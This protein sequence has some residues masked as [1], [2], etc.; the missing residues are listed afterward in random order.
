[1]TD[2][3]LKRRFEA[4]MQEIYDRA[5]KEVGYWATRYLQM[6]RRRGGMD[7]ARYLLH[8]RVTSDGYARLRDAGRLDLTVEALVLRPE[9]A[10]LFD[11][12]ELEQASLRLKQYKSMPRPEE[13]E[14]SAELLAVLE[15]AASASPADRISYR[16]QIAEH[17]SAAIIAMLGWVDQ[18]HSPGLAIAVIEA[19]GRHGE[20]QRALGALRAL[21]G[22]LRDWKSVIDPAVQ[23]LGASPHGPAVVPSARPRRR[24]EP[25]PPRTSTLTLSEA[26]PPALLRDHE[27]WVRS[28]RPAQKGIAWLRDHWIHDFEHLRP[29]LTALP[30]L[31]DRQAVTR[32][33]VEAGRDA[34][35][36]ERAFVAVMAW[37]YG[38]VG[39]GRARAQAILSD[40]AAK[41]RLLGAVR[42]L[43]SD[44]VMAGYQQ[45]ARPG[46]SRLRGLGPAFG[47]KFLYYC[48][49][50]D[51]RPR[52]L[53]LDSGV[54]AWLTEHIGVE[55]D[56]AK[57]SGPTY[58]WYV[59]QVDLWSRAL[60]AAPDDVELC[61][62]RSVQRAGSQ[63]A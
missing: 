14:P 48:Q 1:M 13:Q 31:L 38:S 24:S 42:S 29:M 59:E 58:Q 16:N 56:S 37:G 4:G 35:S 9:F 10:P 41:D 18:G 25:Q 57:W 49:P 30:R 61:I 60:G 39:Y 28:G 17:G 43:V 33:C 62:F 50:A 36:A 8:Q 53:I 51:R 6:L 3:D 22:R 47:P 20:R 44:G 63:W 11:T 46:A 7:T 23:R 32:V 5:G 21:G 54:A 45:L 52:A 40:P 34:E 15:Q 2:A 26:V 27:A 12:A 19:V 55:V